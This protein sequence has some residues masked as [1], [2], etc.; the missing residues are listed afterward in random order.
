MG[1]LLKVIRRFYIKS[2]KIGEMS[3]RMGSRNRMNFIYWGG[4]E[5]KKNERVVQSR[6]ENI[7]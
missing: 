3:D 4:V 1:V 7:I 2:D 6:S 5:E